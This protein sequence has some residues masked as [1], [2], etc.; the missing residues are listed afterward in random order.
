MTGFVEFWRSVG[1]YAY[2]T[3]YDCIL[4]RLLTAAG[5]PDEARARVDAALQIAR[6]PECIFTM[7]S[8]C[9]RV[10][11]PIPT[12]RRAADLAAAIKLARRQDAPLFELRAALDDYELRGDSARAVLSEAADRLT[13]DS[14]L[15][16]LA[17]VQAVLGLTGTPVL[18]GFGV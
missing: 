13:T 16:E 15:P 14:A 18:G 4:G 8:C 11:T 9:G 6:T 7:P 10:P 5:Q 17:R 2:Q 1:L 3:Q 12:L